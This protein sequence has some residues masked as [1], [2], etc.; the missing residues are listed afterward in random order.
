MDKQ[1][2]S[3]N[4]NKKLFLISENELMALYEYTS[5][6]PRLFD[7][8]AATKLF[9]NI[10]SRQVR[11]DMRT[12]QLV[13]KNCPLCLRCDLTMEN[14]LSCQIFNKMS[15]RNSSCLALDEIQYQRQRLFE[16]FSGSNLEGSCDN[17]CDKCILS[18][19][20]GRCIAEKAMRLLH[21]SVREPNQP[22]IIHSTT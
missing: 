5:E 14:V 2:L 8:G 9:H 21:Q 15:V 6:T 1:S 18:D 19:N 4:D 7:S 16:I 17:R 13:C 11:N 22:R 12:R 20:E 10:S 3:V